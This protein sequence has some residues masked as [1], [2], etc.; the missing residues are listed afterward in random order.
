MLFL[1]LVV[2]WLYFF[3]TSEHES[4]KKKRGKK[5]ERKKKYRTIKRESNIVF[6]RRFDLVEE[7]SKG[8]R[9]TRIP[10]VFFL[11]FFP[12][13]SFIVLMLVTRIDEETKSK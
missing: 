7:I 10:V 12:F 4:K 5:A 1:F 6:A 3:L 9:G 11:F 8:R 13:L 2:I